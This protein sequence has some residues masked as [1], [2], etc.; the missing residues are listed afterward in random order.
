MAAAIAHDKRP[1]RRSQGG[2]DHQQGRQTSRQEIRH[3]VD[4]GSPAAKGT[5]A[6]RAIA[7]DL[8]ECVHHLIG[9]HACYSLDRQPEER[10]NDAV[11]EVLCQ[12][13]KGSRTYLLS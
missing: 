7:Y 1:D 3:V 11:A 8:V 6:L 13:L 9:R 10:I 2:D 12:R 5:I 4:M